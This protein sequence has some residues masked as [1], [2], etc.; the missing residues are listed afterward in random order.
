MERGAAEIRLF[1]YQLLQVHKPAHAIEMVAQKYGHRKDSVV[2]PPP[3][4]QTPT[5][6]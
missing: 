1:I 5:H 6:Q 2:A 4:W 3:I